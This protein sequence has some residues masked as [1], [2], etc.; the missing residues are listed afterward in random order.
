[1]NIFEE[2][3]K[4]ITNLI[5][6][7]Q[8]FLNLDNLNDFKGIVVECPPPEF[9]FDLSCN[10]G[11]LLGKINNNTPHRGVRFRLCHHKN[12]ECLSRV[13]WVRD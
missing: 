6:K 9:N 10:A 7:N 4:K 2:Y 8:K 12:K 13:R 3:I 1:M 5:L 11:L